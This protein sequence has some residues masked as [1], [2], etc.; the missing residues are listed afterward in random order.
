MNNAGF[1]LGLADWNAFNGE[2]TITSDAFAGNNALEIST[3]RSGIDQGFSVVTG[4]P[5]T[6]SGY[7]KTTEPSWNGIG[8]SFYDENWTLLEK[9]STRIT[10]Q[11]WAKRNGST[12]LT[13]AKSLAHLLIS[14]RT[15]T[16]I[17]IGA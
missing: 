1:K 5:Y 10:S 14:I 2:A 7:A 6:L 9:T 12:L 11:D 13:T 17:G 15:S 4:E 16:P 8:L 3:N